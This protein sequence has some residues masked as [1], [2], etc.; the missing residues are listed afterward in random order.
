MAFGDVFAGWQ[1]AAKQ[2]YNNLLE[3][4]Y[5]NKE[6]TATNYAKMAEDSTNYSPEQRKIFAQRALQIHT[7]KPGQDFPKEWKNY[8]ITIQ[9]PTAPQQEQPGALPIGTPG[10]PVGMEAPQIAPPTPPA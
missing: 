2:H 8:Q 6:Q 4:D 1:E 9:P 3:M 10:A 7:F 5:R